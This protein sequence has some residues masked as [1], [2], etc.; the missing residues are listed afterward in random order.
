MAWLLH[1]DR[2]L[3]TLEIAEGHRQR[4]RGLVGRDGFD[5][6]LLLLPARSI[7]TFRMRFPLDVAWCDREMT[8]VRTA[9]VEPNRLPLPVPSAHCVIEAEAGAFERWGLVEG[10][11]LD[12]RR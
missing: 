9:H 7:H 3:A 5:G 8:V 1:E 4:A 12:V 6:A 10:T 11:E 2:V